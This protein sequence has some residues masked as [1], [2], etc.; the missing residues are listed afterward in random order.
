M[1]ILGVDPGSRL[2]GFGCVDLLG[3]QIRW[4]RHGVLRLSNTGGKAVIPLHERLL[5]IHRGL[6]ELIRELQPQVLVVE[7]I[8]FAKNA[9]SALQLGQ[10]RGTAILSGAIHGLEIVEYNPSEVKS[11]VTGH[12]NADKE[13]MAK[14]LNLLLRCEEFA[15]FDASDALGLAFCH[16]QRSVGGCRLKAGAVGR[17]RVAARKKTCSLAESIG[18]TEA[19]AKG[20]RSLRL[21]RTGR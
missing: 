15:T 2:T 3:N 16:A 17:S 12:G 11:T 20:R 13:Q 14:M 10:A 9:L 8:F 5:S 7:K 21:D 6:D 19:M 4:V 18:V 1:R